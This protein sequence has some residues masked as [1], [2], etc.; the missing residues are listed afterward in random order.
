[1]LITRQSMHINPTNLS[2]LR[3]D[4]QELCSLWR[5]TLNPRKSSASHASF[6][7]RPRWS[8]LCKNCGTNKFAEPPCFLTTFPG[9]RR[10]AIAPLNFKKL[11]SE[12]VWTFSQSS[13]TKA[14]VFASRFPSD[15]DCEEVEIIRF[16]R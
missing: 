2:L 5:F 4:R 11:K 12:I 10:S 8:A 13:W 1:M 3:D 15:K 9:V 7:F 6:R 16:R 14:L